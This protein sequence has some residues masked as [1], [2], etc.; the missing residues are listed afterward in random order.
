MASRVGYEIYPSL[1]IAR[2]G[3][4]ECAFFLGPEPGASTRTG[5]SGKPSPPAPTMEPIDPDNP[6]EW[7]ELKSYRDAHGKLKRQAA[8][9]R[10]FKVERDA[11]TGIIMNA[12][13][14]AHVPGAS[15]SWKLEL[16][17]T[18]ASV[19]RFYQ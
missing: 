2:L 8:R 1:A 13:E 14:I 10:L 16:A 11:S 4:S 3:K 6:V 15:A 9:F 18:K 19:H 5:W 12:T 17:N 7:V